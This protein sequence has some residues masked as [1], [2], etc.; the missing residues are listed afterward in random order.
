MSFLPA[1][2]VAF[3]E[4]E[5]DVYGPQVGF[6]EVRQA[7][8]TTIQTWSAAYIAEMASRTGLT[9]PDFGTWEAV[10]ANRAL[11]ADLT[12]ACWATCAM[13]D[14]RHAPE[15]QGDGT[16]SARFIADANLVIYGEDWQQSVDLV[17]AYLTAVRTLVLQH[18]TL[19]GLA[20]TSQWVGESSME[21]EHQR[22]RTV[23]VARAS[24]AVT[25]LGVA[26]SL[27][28][29]KTV[30]A[31]PGTSAGPTVATTE[32]TLTN[33]AVDQGLTESEQ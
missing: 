24:F 12:P 30:P 9:M 22:T 31:P 29:P 19:G 5:P 7:L 16:W 4:I 33:A 2:Y 6:R 20:S 21:E 11:P 25:V 13:T 3:P 8:L 27:A 32:I 28:G 23:Q 14:P 17:G 1:G 26:N 18:S 15:R 10:Y